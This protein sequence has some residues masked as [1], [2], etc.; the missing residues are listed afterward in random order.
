MIPGSIGQ[1]RCWE[2]QATR[3]SSHEDVRA[4]QH[5]L[6][7]LL[8]HTQ[9]YSGSLFMN[10]QNAAEEDSTDPCV[11]SVMTECL[12]YTNNSITAFGMKQTYKQE[13]QSYISKN[14]WKRI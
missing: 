4:A 1:L 9:G 13:K 12:A 5:P 7:S 11:F 10:T 6:N 14:L 2:S 3:S 8:K